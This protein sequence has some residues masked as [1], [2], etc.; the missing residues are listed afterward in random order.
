[1]PLPLRLS[2]FYA[3]YFLIMGVQLPFWPVWLQSRGLSS[4]QI[5]TVLAVALWV[6]IIAIPVAGVVVDRTGERRRALV[7][8]SGVAFVASLL[9]LPAGELTV[10]GATG[11]FVAILL[12]TMLMN[13]AFSPVMNLGDNLTLLIA[14]AYQ[15]DYGR[16]RLWGSVSFILASGLGGVVVAGNRPDSVLHLLILATGLT[17]LTCCLVPRPPPPVMPSTG[18]P[19]KTGRIM[20]LMLD[21]SFL[22]F[23]G[24]TAAI[25]SSHAVYYAFGTL[26]WRELG[27]SEA[28]IGALWAEGVVA[29]IVLFAFGTAVIRRLGAGRLLMLAGIGALVRWSGTAVAETLPTLAALQLLHGLT[30]GAAHLAAMRHIASA[31]P[32]DRSATAQALYGAL[33]TGMGTAIAMTLAGAAYAR[34]GAASYHVMAAMGLAGAVLALALASR[35]RHRGPEPAKA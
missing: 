11:G 22:L 33:A 19:L 6:R 30:F 3:A 15:L 23:L 24:A 17:A 9:Y 5:G 27:H 28:V 16:I 2:L 14:R 13:A 21:P 31:V 18:T 26:H 12:V 7:A 1:M 20:A 25:Q 8:L 4:E 29:E 35:E 10:D 32:V 34:I